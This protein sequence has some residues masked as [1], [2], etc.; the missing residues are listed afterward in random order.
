MPKTAYN[1]M[2]LCTGAMGSARNGAPLHLKGTAFH[3][4]IPGFMAQVQGG[5]RV[6][7]GL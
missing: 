1:F 5:V 4:V 6:C 3:R 7:K 2:E